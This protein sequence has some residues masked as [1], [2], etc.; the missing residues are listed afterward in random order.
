MPAS[1]TN[2][3]TVQPSVAAGT[4]RFPVLASFAMPPDDSA[5][6]SSQKSRGPGRRMLVADDNRDV[7][8]SMAMLL[9]LLG[10]EVVAVHDGIEAMKTAE[11][12]RPQIV[13]MD[14]GMPRLNGLDATRRIREQTWG[15]AVIIIAVTALGQ[16]SDRA[17]SREAGCDG[18]LVKPLTLHELEMLLTEL[19]VENGSVDKAEGFR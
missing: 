6:D 19:H 4:P 7:A 10:N 8:T 2:G 17:R 1:E 3:D 11:A 14:V 5:P 16:E 12:F 13:L 9:T 18:H 15:R